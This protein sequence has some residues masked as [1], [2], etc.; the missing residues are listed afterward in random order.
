MKINSLKKQKLGYRSDESFKGTAV[1][2]ALALNE[3]SLEITLTVPLKELLFSTTCLIK[4]MSWKLWT[5]GFHIKISFNAYFKMKLCRYLQRKKNLKICLYLFPNFIHHS[6][7]HLF[8]Y[9]IVTT[10]KIVCGILL[11]TNTIQW[12]PENNG[13]GRRH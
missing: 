5:N 13:I 10:S 2:R 9:S 11:S 1:N 6:I 7:N 3:G 8:P 4:R 12:E